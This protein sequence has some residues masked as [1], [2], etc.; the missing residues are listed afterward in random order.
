MLFA[1]LIFRI[2]RAR[3]EVKRGNICSPLFRL[4]APNMDEGSFIIAS[5]AFENV[6]QVVF[7]I[8]TASADVVFLLGGG[9][10]KEVFVDIKMR[11]GLRLPGLE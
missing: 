7:A 8:V 5:A 11:V 1:Y 10:I 4:N 3:D 2:D 6:Q 9:Y